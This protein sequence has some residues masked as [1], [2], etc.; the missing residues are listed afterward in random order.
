MNGPLPTV[1][2]VLASV[3]ALLLASIVAQASWRRASA[4]TRHLAWNLAL[5]GSL[6]IGVVAACV[7]GVPVRLGILPAP[8]MA[9]AKVSGALARASARSIVAETPTASPPEIVAGSPGAAANPLPQARGLLGIWA[10]G[11]LMLGLWFAFGHLALNRLARDAEVVLDPAWLETVEAEAKRCGW[12]SPIRLIRSS[13]AGSPVTWRVRQLTV[14]LPA[15]SRAWSAD[16]RRAVIAHELAHATRGDHQANLIARLACAAYWFHPLVWYAARELRAESERACDDVVIEQ[17]TP[18]DDYASLLLEVARSS[19]AL[20]LAGL[21]AIGMARPSQLE[22]R[23]LAVLDERRARNA[24]PR[25]VLALAW[26]LLA[27][28]ALPLAAVRPSL[29][30]RD[31]ALASDS[32]G[33]GK[34]PGSEYTESATPGQ[35][36]EID[37]ESGGSLKITGWNQSKVHVRATLGGSDRRDTRVTLDRVSGGLRLHAWQAVDRSSSSTSHHFEIEVPK[38]YDLRLRS[39]GGGLEMSNLEGDFRG[40]PGAARSRS[41]TCGDTRRSRPAAVRSTCPTR[42]SAAR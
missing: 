2:V 10:I 20:R 6:A 26:A 24:P 12:R 9:S 41:R 17:G 29:L 19:R 21:V 5:T 1:W 37:L 14:L 7:P 36:L 23:L 27:L 31:Q 35:R 8:P 11:A 42:I 39:A 3:T 38:K 40:T 18:N 25:R 13:R 28:I 32:D 33:D 22:G 16:K 34:S 30:P 15:E 4:A